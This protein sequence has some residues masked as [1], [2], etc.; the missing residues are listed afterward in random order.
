M[1]SRRERRPIEVIARAWAHVRAGGVLASVSSEPPMTLRQ[2]HDDDG[3]MCALCL[4]GSAAGPLAGDDYALELDVADDAQASLTATGASIAQGRDWLPSSLRMRATIGSN[5]VLVA[6]P[7]ALIVCEGSRVDSFV[8]LELTRTSRVEWHE[9]VVLGRTGDTRSG[10]ATVSWDVRR[11]GRPLLRQRVDLT[12]PELSRWMLSGH[13]VLS[14]V[15]LAG[16]DVQARTVVA[17]RTAVAQLIDEHA[18]LVN[19][20]ADDGADATSQ[21]A[22]LLTCFARSGSQ[23]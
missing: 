19:V 6:E 15:L 22:D 11:D 16:P 10:A 4:V 14:S 9:T 12:D 8:S 7:G 5:A 23:V 13:R 20:L 21:V 1:G 18:V 17:S 2:V 3:Q